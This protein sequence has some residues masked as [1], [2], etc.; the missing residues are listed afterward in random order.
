MSS[1][2]ILG[3]KEAGINNMPSSVC[4]TTMELDPDNGRNSHISGMIWIFNFNSR[5]A[6]T[7]ESSKRIFCYNNSHSYLSAGLWQQE[8]QCSKMEL[9]LHNKWKCTCAAYSVRRR[10]ERCCV[11]F[12][13]AESPLPPQLLLSA[14]ISNLTNY[15]SIITVSTSFVGWLGSII[16]PLAYKCR[17]NSSTNW[18][19]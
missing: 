11:S 9:L 3:L 5:F 13:F 2:K 18:Y 14:V 16:L 19:M 4:V 1:W 6:S 7:I 8:L 15:K 17:M 10:S 12:R